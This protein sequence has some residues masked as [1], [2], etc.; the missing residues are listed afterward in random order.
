[1]D[2][3]DEVAKTVVLRLEVDSGVFKVG[4]LVAADE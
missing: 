1:M 2:G 4:D 3:D